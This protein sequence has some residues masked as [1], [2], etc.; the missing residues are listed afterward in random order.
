M[1]FRPSKHHAPARIAVTVSAATHRM[2]R[3]RETMGEFLAWWQAFAGLCSDHDIDPLA[4]AAAVNN[5]TRRKERHGID[6][7]DGR[8]LMDIKR[9]ETST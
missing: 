5:I 2:R 9:E 4:A 3:D 1:P 6:P 7:M 8:L